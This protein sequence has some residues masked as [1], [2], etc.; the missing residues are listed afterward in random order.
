MATKH[1]DAAGTLQTFSLLLKYPE[2]ISIHTTKIN[3]PVSLYEVAYTIV[4]T[5]NSMI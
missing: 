1:T 4:M 3:M 5:P 2:T